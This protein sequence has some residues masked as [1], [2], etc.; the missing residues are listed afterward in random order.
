MNC[1]PALNID[2]SDAEIARLRERAKTEGV[3]MK[4]LAHDT[5][6]RA[7]TQDTEDDIVMAAYERIRQISANLL[8]RLADR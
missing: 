7:T 3:S 8:R 4:A 2:F 6:I 5:L 1:M